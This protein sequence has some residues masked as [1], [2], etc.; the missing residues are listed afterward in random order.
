MTSSARSSSVCGIVR[1]I[2]LAV[3]RL[4]TDR[5]DAP[6]EP[7]AARRSDS[8]ERLFNHLVQARSQRMRDRDTEHLC[9]LEVQRQQQFAR[10]LNGKVGGFGTPKY[11][12]D[13]IGQSAILL[14]CVMG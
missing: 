7:S 6:S 9:R 13:K 3:L 11:P 12:V 1:P 10:L 2:A 4:I 14:R 8:T 5:D